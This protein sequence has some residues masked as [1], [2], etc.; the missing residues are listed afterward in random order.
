[1]L[2]RSSGQKQLQQ[3]KLLL[4]KLIMRNNFIFYHYVPLLQGISGILD[5]CL[6]FRPRP[7]PRRRRCCSFVLSPLFSC[8]PFLFESQ[9]SYINS[10]TVFYNSWS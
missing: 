7:R 2:L 4:H 9:Q 3:R 6:F 5:F 1:M 8:F 10:A